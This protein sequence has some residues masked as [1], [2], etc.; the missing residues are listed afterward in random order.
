MS[1]MF[2]KKFISDEEIEIILSAK[3]SLLFKDNIP[4]SKKG[5]TNFDVAQG[6]WDGAETCELTGL[7]ILSEL[8]EIP[9]LNV[10]INRDDCLGETSA[11]PRQTELI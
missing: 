3:K 1:I 4:W 2:C 8:S 11:S 10:G 9:R 7:Y 6:S 5:T